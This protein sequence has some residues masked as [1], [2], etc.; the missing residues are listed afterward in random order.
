MELFKNYIETIIM[1]LTFLGASAGALV[2]INKKIH[3][4]KIDMQNKLAETK[5]DIYQ[6]DSMNRALAKNEKQ[7][8]MYEQLKTCEAHNNRIK[9]LESEVMKLAK[10]NQMFL[11]SQDVI[12]EI[13][14]PQGNGRV[15]NMRKELQTHIIESI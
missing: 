2:T 9:L 5:E 1:L 13:L 14:E 3:E 8:E 6:S 15:K 10:F 7:K 12:L 11:K 4:L